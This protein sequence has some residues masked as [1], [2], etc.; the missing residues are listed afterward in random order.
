MTERK[1]KNITKVQSAFITLR[2]AME[3]DESYVWGWFCNLADLAEVTPSSR[4]EA[5]EAAADFIIRVFDF[6]V[7][8]TQMYKDH[9]KDLTKYREETYP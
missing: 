7:R 9:Q 6:D 8:K 4:K 1:V 2:E 3:N 5:E